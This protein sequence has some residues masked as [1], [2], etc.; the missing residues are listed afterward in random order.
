MAS[1][2]ARFSVPDDPI[3]LSWEAGDVRGPVE[4]VELDKGFSFLL[5]ET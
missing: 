4:R 2:N 5:G 3:M 1:S